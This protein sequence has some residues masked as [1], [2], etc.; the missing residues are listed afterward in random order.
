[1][2]REIP[3]EDVVFAEIADRLRE[4]Y[5]QASPDDIRTAVDSARQH[6]GGAKVRDFVPVL[7]E[8]EARAFL[9]RSR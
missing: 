4:R 8:R 2:T 6:F 7:V 3:D 9:D 1:M 5:P